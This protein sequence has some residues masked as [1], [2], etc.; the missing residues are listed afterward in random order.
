MNWLDYALLA[1]VLIGALW[2]IKS[3]ILDSIVYAILAFLGWYLAG[4]IGPAIG[5]ALKDMVSNDQIITTVSFVIVIASVLWA[6]HIVWKIVKPIMSVVTLGTTVIIDR[7]GGLILGLL[8]GIALVGTV[9]II[10]ARL[11]YTF[12]TQDV[13]DLIPGQ[14]VTAQ[15]NINSVI[16]SFEQTVPDT[17]Q[18]ADILQKTEQVK[19]AIRQDLTDA[20]TK[21]VM[22]AIADLERS[23]R[24]F[25][26]DKNVRKQLSYLSDLRETIAGSRDVIDEQ[27][28][29][30]RYDLEAALTESA[31]VGIFIGVTETLPGN[32]LGFIPD[33][34]KTSMDMLKENMDDRS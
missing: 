13:V 15:T 7:A 14:L 9:I 11:T 1:I 25:T 34:F 33:D 29:S 24:Q 2:G 10:L 3:G 22:D 19:G 30:V 31:V 21:E 26:P 20:E 28:E 12:D 4:Q 18:L 5:D 27:V 32:T 8:I 23:V 17:N 16:S 6:G